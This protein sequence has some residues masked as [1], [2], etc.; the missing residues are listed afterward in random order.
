[1]I[2]VDHNGDTSIAP[3]RFALGQDVKVLAAEAAFDAGGQKFSAG[4]FIF[5]AVDRARLEPLIKEY[6]LA[7]TAVSSVPT[8]KTHELA[9]PRI[10]YVHSWSNTQNEGW[11]R[12]AFD[13][14][15]IPYTYMGDTKLREPNLRQKYDV[16][17][18]PHVG[19][20]AES[21]VNGVQGAQP[22][23]YK[24]TDL[25]PN[26]GVQDSAD[27]IR[28]GMGFEGLINLMKFVRMAAC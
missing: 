12:M 6:G 18:F 3:F 4:S 9:L 8:V 11:V 16:I 2:V 1:V 19:G 13:K 20:T 26:L 21:Q 15:K 14:L 25:T 23:P 10:G 27:D 5:P 28:G 22:I 7:A 24:K 17:I